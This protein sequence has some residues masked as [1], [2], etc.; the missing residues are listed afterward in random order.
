[1]NQLVK[2]LQSNLYG[3]ELYFAFYP[4]N[5]INH[6][7]EFTEAMDKHLKQIINIIAR[8][9]SQDNINSALVTEL[10]NIRPEQCK[11]IDALLQSK[12]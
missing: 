9:S 8:D 11:E 10:I 3:L 12:N 1:M 7:Q 2:Q 4:K 5:K 6:Y